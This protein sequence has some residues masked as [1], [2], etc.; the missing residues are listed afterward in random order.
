MV[1]IGYIFVAN[2]KPSRAGMS[3]SFELVEW[4]VC[5]SRLDFALYSYPKEFWGNGVRSYVNFK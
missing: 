3:E 2:I 1:H 4:N 5:V